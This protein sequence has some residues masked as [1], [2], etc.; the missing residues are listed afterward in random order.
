MKV[1]VISG[2]A[3]GCL[4]SCLLDA[5]GAEQVV[6]E[7]RQD[8][9][10]EM[11]AKGIRLRG[12]IDWQGFPDVRSPGEPAGP[13]DFIILANPA[14]AA[15]AALRPLSPFVHR[16]TVYLSMQEGSAVEDLAQLVGEYRTGGTVPR[17][18]AVET[19]GG[20]VDVEELRSLSI[21]GFLSTR[22]DAFSPLV[23]A[24]NAGYP[25][26]AALSDDLGRD[27]WGRLEAAATVSALCGVLGGAP[28]EIRGMDGIDKLCSEAAGECRREAQADGLEMDPLSSPWEEAVWKW[29][30]PPLL[31]DLEAGKKT[32]VDFLSGYIVRHAR[33]RGESAPVHSAFF[34]L[35]KEMEAGKRSPGEGSFK[36]LRRRIEEERGMNLL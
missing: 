11:R 1:A 3:T 30:K 24:I 23:D 20:E 18:S 35:I 14:G 27:I 9:L 13:F 16:E 5:G 29:I 4:I 22:K 12:A 36:E 17:F 25:G 26:K 7:S 32:E 31:R 10:A 34:S 8:R 15:G 28:E 2:G 33:A 19:S 6:Y 21:G